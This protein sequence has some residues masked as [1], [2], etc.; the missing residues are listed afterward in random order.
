DLWTGPESMAAQEAR[1]A[2]PRPSERTDPNSGPAPRPVEPSNRVVPP[3]TRPSPLRQEDESLS[4]SWGAPKSYPE[5]RIRTVAPRISEG[6]SRPVADPNRSANPPR[7][8]ET[9]P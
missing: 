1:L 6:A 9:P 2:P 7:R 3:S 5:D 8:S 4:R